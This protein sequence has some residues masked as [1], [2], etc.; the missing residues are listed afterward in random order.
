MLNHNSDRSIRLK[1]A[2]NDPE[3]AGKN[4]DFIVSSFKLY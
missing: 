1:I 3:K 4:D 2:K